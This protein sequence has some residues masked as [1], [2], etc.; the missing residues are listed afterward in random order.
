MTG[1]SMYKTTDSELE[2][3]I[4]KS[5]PKLEVI[6]LPNFYIDHR[7]LTLEFR[8][9]D[10][11]YFYDLKICKSDLEK[12][13][14]INNF[15]NIMLFKTKHEFLFADIPMSRLLEIASKIRRR[16]NLKLFW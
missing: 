4:I 16:G 14:T 1:Y 9:A 6:Q 3:Y 13:V 8:G 15:K 11:M 7:K 10:I 12:L 2:V 5:F